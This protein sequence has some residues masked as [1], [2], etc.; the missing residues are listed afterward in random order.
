[1]KSL[2]HIV[3]HHTDSQLW[4]LSVEVWMVRITSF[5]GARILGLA[6]LKNLLCVEGFGMLWHQLYS[7]EFRK[8]C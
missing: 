5:A 6:V 7:L 8:T 1:M 3:R 2:K 4:L